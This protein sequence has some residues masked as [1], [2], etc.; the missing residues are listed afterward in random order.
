MVVLQI[1][2]MIANKNYYRCSALEGIAQAFEL[3]C[4]AKLNRSKMVNWR[5]AKLS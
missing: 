5:A 2:G 3:K 4:K 1:S